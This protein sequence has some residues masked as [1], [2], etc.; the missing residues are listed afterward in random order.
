MN[1]LLKSWGRS[2]A[3]VTP[4]STRLKPI[5][6]NYREGCEIAVK[7]TYDPGNFPSRHIP[8]PTF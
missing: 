1:E 4:Y 6:A 2:A 3:F 8:K 5:L 7:S